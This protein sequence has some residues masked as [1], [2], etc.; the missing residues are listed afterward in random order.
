LGN[1]TH[2]QTRHSIGLLLLDYIASQLNLTWSKDKSIHAYITKPTTIHID[3]SISSK[4]TQTKQSKKKAKKKKWDFGSESDEDA[5][6]IT[7]NDDTTVQDEND[8]RPPS[9]QIISSAPIFPLNT[10]NPKKFKPKPDP[11]PLELT[12]LK[13]LLLMNDSGKSVSRAGLY[14]RIFILCNLLN[15]ELIF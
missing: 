12:L 5:K 1:Y 13:P 10:S 7:I 6:K 3:P 14:L 4:Q 8:T 11:V 2:Q 15:S 9:P